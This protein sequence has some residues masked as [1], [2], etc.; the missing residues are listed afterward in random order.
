MKIIFTIGMTIVFGI[1]S[2]S[3]YKNIPNL[4]KLEKVETDVIINDVYFYGE[5]MF[6]ESSEKVIK[7][8][9]NEKGKTHTY[10]LENSLES[11][12][13]ISKIPIGKYSVKAS[14][15]LFDKNIIGNGEIKREIYTITRNNDNKK[16]EVSLSET[17]AIISI[18][19][20]ELPTNVYDVIIDAGHGGSDS[21]ACWDIMCEREM[22]LQ[23]SNILKENLEEEGL[24]VAMTRTDNVT[25]SEDDYYMS[26]YTED[27]RVVSAYQKKAKIMI[28]NHLN[29][30]N[31]SNNSDVKGF[32]VYQSKYTDTKLSEAIVRNLA[33]ITTKS[34]KK[35]G[36]IKNGIYAHLSDDFT[37]KPYFLRKYIPSD[38][39]YLIR[40]TGG[41]AI[42]ATLVKE[43]SDFLAE[44]SFKY[45]TQSIIVEYAY[46]S[47]ETDKKHFLMT[48]EEYA[49]KVSNAIIEYVQ[50]S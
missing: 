23:F 19:K 3:L 16:I 6:F 28:S 5:K 49:K 39:F 10:S 26:P 33:E 43:R 17:E 34:S 27:G 9:L 38:F 18:T 13:D 12:V 45:G 1:M 41:E 37:F 50:K 46:I 25:W 47:N 40:E 35:E 36:E 44:E 42:G 31:T 21:G 2:Q 20:E 7:L 14:T 30:I 15:R 29:S 48:Y 24:K 4:Y 8:Y 32:E 11:G 22:M